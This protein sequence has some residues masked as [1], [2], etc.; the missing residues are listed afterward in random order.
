MRR[1]LPAFGL[2]IFVIF[3]ASFKDPKPSLIS[4]KVILQKMSKVNDSLYAGKYEVSNLDYR[5][6]LAE[7]AAKD[8]SLAEKYKVD[9]TKWPHVPRY[10]EPMTINQ[11]YHR[12]PAFSDYPV[13][14]IS[15]A[16][17]MEY[18][19]W[20]TETYHK[21]PKRKFQKV[22]F[23]LP[24]GN[25]WTTAAQGGR[26]NAIFP[27]GN[28]YLVNKKG[29]YM[30]NFKAVGD[31]YVVKD[32]LGKP[33]IK[34]YNGNADLHAAE[35]PPKSF[36]TMNVR[37]FTP[38]DLGMYNAC[39][40]AA[41]MILEQGNAMGGSWNSYGGEVSTTSTKKYSFPSPEVGFRVFMRIIEP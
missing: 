7:I 9:S 29:F 21:D 15:Y 17:A 18:C 38:N 13:V 4:A 39:G 32:S 10:G 33:V 14:N 20:L 19:N 26:S 25:E 24:S 8:P 22:I 2:F 37:S 28:Y 12:H 3:S 41:E 6:F 27:W 36:Y 5:N 34:N 23:T 31:P 11:R 40:N 35:F 1:L 30:C 16:A